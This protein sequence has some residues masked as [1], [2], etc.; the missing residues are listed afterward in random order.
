MEDKAFIQVVKKLWKKSEG[1]AV[2]ARGASGGLGTLWNPNKY[3]RI[4]EIVNT[5]WL[6]TKLQHVDSD[7]T[8][9]LFNVYVPVSAGEKKNCWDTI[10]S[11]AESEELANIIIAGDLNLTLSSAEKR[12]GSI[13]RDPAREQVED[14]L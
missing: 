10:R 12:G 8:L 11:L 2:S 3:S 7:E 1:V 4:K 9:C 13:V 6:F 14:L 5:H